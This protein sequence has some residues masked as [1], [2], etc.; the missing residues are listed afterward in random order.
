MRKILTMT[1]KTGN[2]DADLEVV[3]KKQGI[4]AGE[5][6][7]PNTVTNTRLDASDLVVLEDP[8]GLPLQILPA[9]NP[10]AIITT[11]TMDVRD[12]RRMNA[13]TT[14]TDAVVR[15]SMVIISEKIEPITKTTGDGKKTGDGMM[16]ATE[17]GMTIAMRDEKKLRPKS[18]A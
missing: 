16:I 2:E 11:K 18:M 1:R 6:R 8:T 3:P 14:M 5:V 12:R 13:G 9:T 4:A 15:I 10:D 17:T 7:A